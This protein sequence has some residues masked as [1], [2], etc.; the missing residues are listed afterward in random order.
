MALFQRV[1]SPSI[2]DEPEAPTKF[3]PEDESVGELLRRQ[4]TEMGLHL[5]EVAAAL[6]IKP[7]YLS[8]I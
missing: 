3:K 4:R 5:L 7:A 1:R 8:A 6:K 2:D